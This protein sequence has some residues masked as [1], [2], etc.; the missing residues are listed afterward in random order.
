MKKLHYSKVTQFRPD[1]HDIEAEISVGHSPDF[2]E[3]QESEIIY[4]S[5]DNNTQE[6]ED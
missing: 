3:E 6:G 5:K 1:W 4:E 2:C